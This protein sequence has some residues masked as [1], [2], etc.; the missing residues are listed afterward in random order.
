MK[1]AVP[2]GDIKS[3]DEAAL[4]APANIRLRVCLV[5]SESGVRF[6]ACAN[7]GGAPWFDFGWL[8]VDE[9]QEGAEDDPTEEGASRVLA[10][11]WGFTKWKGKYYAF[12]N[13]YRRARVHHQHPVLRKY[14][15]L[16]VRGARGRSVAPFFAVSVSSVVG[17]VVVF[18]DPDFSSCNNAESRVL[19]HE[20]FKVLVGGLEG[21]VPSRSLFPPP[22]ATVPLPKNA[23]VRKNAQNNEDD[24]ESEEEESSSD[25]ESS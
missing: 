6:R 1:K 13:Y 3:L 16:P 17:A 23:D 15:H 5:H 7:Y 10:K 20:P 14:E 12:V 22:P 4:G 9:D 18:P 25:S 19:V 24:S 21:S 2:E 8:R 11:F